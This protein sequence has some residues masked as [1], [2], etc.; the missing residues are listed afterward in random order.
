LI[1]YEPAGVDDRVLTV[2]LLEKV[3]DPEVGLKEHEAPDGNPLQARV[4]GC[5]AR[6]SRPRVMV[7]DPD[8]P[9]T[10]VIAPED[11]IEKSNDSKA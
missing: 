3:G 4:T 2:R 1:E 11:K 5:D 10:T 6:L 7:L 9:C 8:P